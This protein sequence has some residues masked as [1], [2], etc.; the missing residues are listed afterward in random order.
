MYV[1][2]NGLYVYLVGNIRTLC[3]YNMI[4]LVACTTKCIYDFVKK[5]KDIMKNQPIGKMK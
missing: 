1:L 5:Y 2:L 3:N 4:M